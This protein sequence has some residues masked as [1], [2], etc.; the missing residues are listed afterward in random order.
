MPEATT[1]PAGANADPTQNQQAPQTAAALEVSRK[2]AI[3]QFCEA[4]KLDTRYAS[5]WISE[6]ASLETV[7]EQIL[8]VLKERGKDNPASVADIGMSARDVQRYSLFRMIGA[9]GTNDYSKAGF[10][11]ECHKA[12][13]QSLKRDPQNARSF[14]VPAE[15]L[16]AD[17]LK[18]DLTAGSG[19]AGGFLV[20]TQNVSFIELLRNRS[21][22]MAM[23]MTRLPGMVGNVTI[24]RQTGAVAANWLTDE[25]GAGGAEGNSTWG[26]VAMSPKTVVAY[27]EISRLLQL[28]SNP[29]A[30]GLVMTDV[31]ASV[32]LA[33]DLGALNGSGASGQPTG[34]INTAGIGSFSG[35]T[36]GLPAVIE[37]QTDAAAANALF[38]T[39]GYVANPTVAGLLMQRQRFTSTDTP[40]WEG[41]VLDGKILGYRAMSSNQM[42]AARLLFGDF[43]KIVLA[44]WGVLEI[45]VNEV[46]NFIAGIIGIRAMYSIDVGVRYPGAFSYSTAVT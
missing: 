34:V 5:K 3:T 36:I 15:F 18:R 27:Q 42:P 43:S 14:F 4:N 23:G 9:V 29:S 26:Q 45:G 22:M 33:M 8:E 32:A 1:A 2:R 24:P 35:T 6:G 44:E 37:A 12:V 39:S 30:E 40:I 38:A 46:A 19:A 11:L 31:A 10:E 28:Q 20:E 41:N 7:A 25:A 21:V 13:S 16:K 17:I